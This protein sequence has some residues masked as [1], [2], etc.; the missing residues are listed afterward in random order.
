MTDSLT[1]GAARV[2]ITPAYPVDLTGYACPRNPAIGVLDRIYV[3]AAVFD[4]GCHRVVIV[5]LDILE[6]PRAIADDLR[7]LAA[8][9]AGTTPDHVCLACTHTHAAPAAYSLKEC[10]SVS[11]RFVEDLHAKTSQVVQA[12][13]GQI[14]PVRLAWSSA[15]LDIGGNRRGHTEA[16]TA[17][18]VLAATDDAGRTVCTLLNYACHGVCLAGDNRLISGD[19]PG[20]LCRTLEQGL[21]TGGVAIFLNGCTGDIDPRDQY[22][23]GLAGLNAAVT[24]AAQAAAAALAHLRPSSETHL[25]ADER[26]VS[27]PYDR[28][29]PGGE[30]AMPVCLQHLAIGPVEIVALSG[31]VLYA[32][33]RQIQ[34]RAAREALWVAAYCNGGH[35]Y[36]CTDQAL[37]EGGY[38]PDASNYYYDRPAILPGAERVLVEAGLRCLDGPPN[39]GEAS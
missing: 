10:G 18:R 38:E 17:L 37:A 11:E 16:D 30:T 12:A 22:R 34:D 7:R 8:Q 26:I 36:V 1:C 20:G 27:L 25:A 32:I 29:A 3:R 33:G 6:L 4:N 2:D 5:G 28:P 31:E 35:G 15:P 39:P 13:A 23:G 9:L 24:R 19:W 21:G 14:R